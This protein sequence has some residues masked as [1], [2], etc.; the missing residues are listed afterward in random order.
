MKGSPGVAGSWVRYL[1]KC[2]SKGAS[3]FEVLVKTYANDGAGLVNGEG[4]SSRR[5]VS[6]GMQGS[7]E[8]RWGRND[9]MLEK[10]ATDDTSLGWGYNKDR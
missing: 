4:A 8:T 10:D 2:Q 6:T 9:S 5:T 7:S 1:R 3:R